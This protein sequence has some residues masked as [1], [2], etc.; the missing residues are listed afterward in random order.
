[1]YRACLDSTE[2]MAFQGHQ[3]K[4]GHQVNL[5]RMDLL[6]PQELLASLGKLVSQD[7]QVSQVKLDLPEHPENTVY[8][9]MLEKKVHRVLLVPKENKDPLVLQDS[10]VSQAREDLPAFQ[11]CQD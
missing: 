9:V 11:V 1:M 5:A 4:E 7:L 3:E 8:L 6:A 2:R 10:R